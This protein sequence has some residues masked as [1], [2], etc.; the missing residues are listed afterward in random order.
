MKKQCGTTWW[1]TEFARKGRVTHSHRWGIYG[2]STESNTAEVWNIKKT[3]R[4]SRPAR[5]NYSLNKEEACTFSNLKWC[6]GALLLIAYLETYVGNYPVLVHA[7]SIHIK[8]NKKHKYM[9]FGK[10][11]KYM[12]FGSETIKSTI[13]YI[14]T[15]R[16]SICSLHCH[17]NSGSKHT[18]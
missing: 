18:A 10:K 6:R 8:V 15:G 1:C 12:E 16:K 13:H 3:K 5:G 11:H 14:W 7:S 4:S 2:P 9:E 17:W